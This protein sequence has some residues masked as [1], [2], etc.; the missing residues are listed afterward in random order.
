MSN[1]RRPTSYDR[2]QHQLICEMLGVSDNPNAQGKTAYEAVVDLEETVN[3]YREKMTS[4]MENKYRK[5]ITNSMEN[6]YREEIASLIIDKIRLKKENEELRHQVQEKT[7]I[8]LKKEEIVRRHKTGHTCPCCGGRIYLSV[9]KSDCKAKCYCEFCHLNTGWVESMT[10]AFR[11]F[12]NIYNN[13]PDVISRN[14]KE[15]KRV[16]IPITIMVIL[17]AAA[18][19]CGFIYCSY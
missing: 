17:I 3:K 14:K 13:H 7:T 6:K 15:M 19:F 12:D 5:E 1:K 4:S 9:K 16:F 18:I 10:C 8:K 11:E 2:D